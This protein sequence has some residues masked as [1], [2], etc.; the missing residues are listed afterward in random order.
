MAKQEELP[1]QLRI[2][3]VTSQFP[4]PGDM[5]RGLPVYQTVKQLARLADVRVVSP[6]AA[7]PR[8][9]RPRSYTYHD[10]PESI[11]AAVPVRYAGFTVLPVLSR[12]I[13]G[14]LCAR[15]LAG[16]VRDA[17]PDVILS[18]WLYP[19][20]YGACGAARRLGI[21]VVA[22][23]RGS[24]LLARD[25][26]SRHL[27]RKVLRR[28]DQVLV[29]SRDLERVALACKGVRRERVTTI[30][31][32]CDADLF[33]P[34]DRLAAR[35]LHAIEPDARLL[36]Y[37]GRL[38]PEKGLSELLDAVT[39]LRRDDQSIRL[40]IIGGGPMRAE[41]Q[42]RIDKTMPAGISLLGPADPPLVAS[43]MAA[44][45]LVVLPSYSEGYPNVLV[46]TLACGRPFVAT[47][48]GGVTEIAD[49]SCAVLV[50][51]RNSGALARGIL[52]A[53]RRDW[54]PVALARL[55]SRSWEDAARETLAVCNRAVMESRGRD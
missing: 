50:P 28:A 26:I 36:L 4:L 51:P 8:G 23:A 15:A 29:V 25:W 10:A 37:V 46:E 12:P 21:P 41:L 17:R 11:D 47:P 14:W 34:R 44:A 38:V 3:V 33:R 6:V 40:A 35:S 55:H 22:G 54:D 49:T 1:G 19:D 2:L 43:W 18:Y 9:I 27:A 5:Q 53:L 16:P 42:A 24:D 39:A 48:V 52:E 7:Y 30:A 32:G 13:N 31:N 45:D 20:A